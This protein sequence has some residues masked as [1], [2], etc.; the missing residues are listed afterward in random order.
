[1]RFDYYIEIPP[2][3][4]PFRL[5][6]SVNLSSVGFDSSLDGIRGNE[7]NVG[8]SNHMSF[9]IYM[10]DVS[11]IAVDIILCLFDTMDIYKNIY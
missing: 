5:T 7:C 3:S 10:F 9:V 4:I 11:W 1:M 8:L 2:K 6:I